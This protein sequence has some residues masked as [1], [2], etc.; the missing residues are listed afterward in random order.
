M[1]KHN[2]YCIYSFFIFSLCLRYQQLALRIDS[3]RASVC[4]SKA[5]TCSRR[6]RW[7]SRRW[8]LAKTHKENRMTSS[9]QVFCMCVPSCD[10]RVFLILPILLQRRIFPVWADGWVH[11]GVVGSGCCVDVWFCWSRFPISPSN[12][13]MVL[14][15]LWKLTLVVTHVW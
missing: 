3:W 1:I 15:W 8:R 6:R 9:D 13:S 10:T 5:W 7:G 4:P 11:Q 12:S 14:A 2:C